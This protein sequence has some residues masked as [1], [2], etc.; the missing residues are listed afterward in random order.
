MCVCVCAYLYTHKHCMYTS[1]LNCHLTYSHKPTD[2]IE[3]DRYLE[4]PFLLRAVRCLL[5]LLNTCDWVSLRISVYT[6]LQVCPNYTACF[7]V[8][9]LPLMKD[10]NRKKAAKTNRGLDGPFF[11]R[12]MF[13]DRLSVICW[14]SSK[15]QRSKREIWSL[16]LSLSSR[17]SFHHS[18]CSIWHMR[19]EFGWETDINEA[20]FSIDNN[21]ESMG[22]DSNKT[23][24]AVISNSASDSLIQAVP[25]H[26]ISLPHSHI[27][28]LIWR[29][30]VNLV[31]LTRINLS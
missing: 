20:V 14:L 12:K 5:A 2:L 9:Q 18:F 10:I 15:V 16:S 23:F 11:F 22:S 17:F 3:Q 28:S 27:Y 31:T 30:G 13:T 6:F 26:S 21:S 25:L 4:S 8:P 29:S 19:Y 24:I 7:D 1:I